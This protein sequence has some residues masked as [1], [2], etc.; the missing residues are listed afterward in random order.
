MPHNPNPNVIN[1]DINQIRKDLGITDTP[2]EPLV[3]G[4]EVPKIPNGQVDLNALVA[5][6][7]EQKG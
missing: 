1:P 5:K 6:A 3:K 4:E 2:H 7:K